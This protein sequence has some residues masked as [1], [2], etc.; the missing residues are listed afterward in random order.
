MLNRSLSLFHLS[1]VSLNLLVEVGTYK[2]SSGS[3]S[4]KPSTSTRAITTYRNLS[5]TKEQELVQQLEAILIINLVSFFG[6]SAPRLAVGLHHN[7]VGLDQI[8]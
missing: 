2:P 7:F 3:P 5:T 1:Q 8:K 4:E 6:L